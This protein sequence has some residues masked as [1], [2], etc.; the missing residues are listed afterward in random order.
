MKLPGA[1]RGRRAVMNGAARACVDACV[2]G[3]VGAGGPVG[4]VG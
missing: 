4:P 1:G 2:G 3:C